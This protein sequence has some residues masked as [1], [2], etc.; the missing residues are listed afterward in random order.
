[1]LDLRVPLVLA[2]QSPRR[3]QLLDRLGVPFSVHPSDA[4]ETV[5]P[6]T[7]PVETVHRLA[8]DKAEA[9]A[10]AFPTALTLG[11]DTIV[12]LDG[13]VLGKPTNDTHA[14]EMLARLSGRS[15]TVFTGIALV[16]PPRGRSVTAHEA[17][18]VTFAPLSPEEIEAYVRT[19]SPRDKAGA[20]GI[21]DD[22]GALFVEG[23]RGDY[24][25]VVGLPLHRL[26]QTLRAHF[27]DLLV[28]AGS[29]ND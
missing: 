1:M 25:N 24:Y 28:P 7:S 10:Q 22:A 13:D 9:V 27:A 12:V 17:T 23:V 18:E 4:D 19:G 16:D 11:A 15:H 3:R 14:A 26:Y 6:G 21:Q 20:Y 2:S 8:R 29:P 5:P